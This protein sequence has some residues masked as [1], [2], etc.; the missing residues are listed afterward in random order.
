MALHAED[1]LRTDLYRE[2]ENGR[3]VRLLTKLDFINERPEYEGDMKWS[4]YGERYILKLFRDYVFHAIDA[5]T[6]RP[7]LDLGHVLVC[8]NK[9]DAGTNEQI[10][11]DSQDGVS[12]IIVTYKELKK[13]AILAFADLEKRAGAKGGRY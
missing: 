2:L 13:Q 3:L 8:L 7:K 4:E 5:E 9:L 10:R 11:L 1:A 12:S 6:R